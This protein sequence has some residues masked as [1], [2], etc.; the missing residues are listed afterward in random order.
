MKNRRV[1]V[2]G[3]T[4]FRKSTIVAV[5]IAYLLNVPIALSPMGRN[6]SSENLAGERRLSSRFIVIDIEE[7]NHIWQT[8]IDVKRCN[9]G[10]TEHCQ[11]SIS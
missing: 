4:R 6:T 2:K 10:S 9:P 3:G 7:R 1:L 11:L 8:P 5:M